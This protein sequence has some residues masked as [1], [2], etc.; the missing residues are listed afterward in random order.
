[1]PAARQIDLGHCIITLLNG[2][3]LKLDG[4]AMF[5]IIPKALWSR[6]TP[7]DEQ[8]RIQLACNCLLVEFANRGGT[9]VIIEAGHGGK[10]DE[11]EQ[12][13]FGIDPAR[14]LWHALED[15]N[16]PA[17]S[18]TDVIMT[19]LHFD[20]GG[21]LTRHDEDGNLVPTFPNARVHV[22]DQELA[23]ARAEFGL[24]TSTYRTENL[25][26]LDHAE[27][28]NPGAGDGEVVPGIEVLGA[29]GHTRGHQVVVVH[30]VQQSLLFSGDLLPT[31]AHIGAPW[32]M[33]FDLFPL[34]NR[35]SK[36][37]ILG[38]AADERWLL[39]VCHEPG[40][41]LCRVARDGDWFRLEPA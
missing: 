26:P 19:H 34:D 28:W 33:G 11:K 5:G 29:L 17:D 30:G 12:R 21:G 31:K 13:I 25:A 40:D 38:R 20:H 6:K 18:I 24:M 15:A 14:W 22:R 8:N 3:A 23:D 37:R 32:N 4:G 41:P 35:E 10:Y 27:R 1:M 39:A 36:R 16:T 7:A 2:G 9:R